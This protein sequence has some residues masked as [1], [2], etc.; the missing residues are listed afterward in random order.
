MVLSALA[1]RDRVA[2]V[3]SGRFILS[4]ATLP[5]YFTKD[6]NQDAV[7]DAS[8]D[9]TIFAS[10][11]APALGIKKRFVGQEPFD[12]ITRQYN[13]AMKATLPRHGIELI[14]IPRLEMEGR[15]ISASEVRASLKSGDLARI[16]EIVPP[17]TYD[18]L[19]E[20]YISNAEN[21]KRLYNS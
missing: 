18:Y 10:K 12:K 20:H 8:N 5:E 19:M 15:A 14:E 16:A 13:E 3:P 7:L 6:M 21:M 9:L 17:T 11:I 1:G 2:V 4:N